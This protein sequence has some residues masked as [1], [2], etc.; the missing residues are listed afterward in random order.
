MGFTGFSREGDR[1]F[2]QLSTLQDREWFKQHKAEYVKLWEAPMKALFEELAPKMAKQ[3]A[4]WKLDPPKHFRIYRD[5]RFSKDKAPFKT[6]IAATIHLCGG[7]EAPT[8][9]YAH[10]GVE[11]VVG[12]GHWMMS[13][14]RLKRYRQLIVDEKTGRELQK[15]VDALEK[16]G[17]QIEAMESLKRV[18][19]GFDAEHPRA[20]L[21]KHK[22]LGITFPKIPAG[23][24]NSPKLSGWIVEQ[25][26]VVAP[27]VKWVEEKL[28]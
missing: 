10:F 26:A 6:N 18:P 12:A 28:A 4:G 16:K 17:F 14:E 20:A 7:E 13:P 2:G 22:G 25:S 3:Y 24:R 27:L 8:A 23:V 5:V 15:R 11:D 21:L 19:V 1:F 9:I